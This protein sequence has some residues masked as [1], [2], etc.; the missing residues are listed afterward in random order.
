MRNN[1]QSEFLRIESNTVAGQPDSSSFESEGGGLYLHGD[2]TSYYG[3]L[4]AIAG[5]SVG[6]DG[7]RWRHLHRSAA[8]PRPSSRRGPPWRA[9]RSAPGGFRESPATAGHARPCGTRSL[10]GRRGEWAVHQG[11]TSGTRTR[12]TPRGG[13]HGPGEHRAPI[14]SSAGGTNAHQTIV[15]PDDRQGRRHAVNEEVGERPNT[16]YEGDPRP[17]DG[18]GDGHTVDMGADETPAASSRVRLLLPRTSRSAPT[19]STTTATA[20][21]TALTRAVWRA[22][23]TTTRATRRRATSCCADR[24]TSA[25]C[26]RT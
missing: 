6:E 18:D 4:D 12:A 19:W 15:E 21:S 13:L 3:F 22:R 8:T 7:T 11:T 23:R 2:G 10:Y 9:T 16:D 25:W 14:R 24:A 1:I 26:G 20:R 5:N 17:T